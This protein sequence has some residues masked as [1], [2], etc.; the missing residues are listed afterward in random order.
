MSKRGSKSLGWKA[1]NNENIFKAFVLLIND[2]VSG[3]LFVS[4]CWAGG[5]RGTLYF[6]WSVLEGGFEPWFLLSFPDIIVD[7]VSS[8]SIDILWLLSGLFVGDGFVCGVILSVWFV[9]MDVLVGGGPIVVFS[10]GKGSGGDKCN[11]ESSH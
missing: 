9:D 4:L 5:V 8:L 10:P 2:I 3:D 6:L 11:C 7:S 1:K